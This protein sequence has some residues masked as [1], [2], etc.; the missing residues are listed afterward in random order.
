MAS[1]R[2]SSWRFLTKAGEPLERPAEWTE[3]LIEVFAEDWTAARVTRN[4]SE[5]AVYAGRVAHGAPR[6]LVDWPRSGAG[7]YHVEVTVAGQSEH[8]LVTLPPAKL[9][10]AAFEQLLED[11]QLRLP[12]SIAVSLARSGAL[13]GIELLPKAQST[14]AQELERARRAIHGRPG[15]PGLAAV[16]TALADD[17][18]RTFVSTDVWVRRERARRL[19]PARLPLLLARGGNLDADGMPERVPELRVE[20]TVDVYENRLVRT[21]H[22]QVANRVRRLRHVDGEFAVLAGQLG[23]ARRRASFLDDVRPPA[24]APDRVTMVLLKQPHY[25]AALEGFV[26]YTRTAAVQL[27]EPALEAPLENVPALYEHWGVLQ[28]LDVLLQQAPAAGFEITSTTLSRRQDAG[29]TI[30]LLPGGTP[31]AQ[32]RHQDGRCARLYLQRTYTRS[33]NPL[34]SVSFDK[35]PDAAL[36]IDGGPGGR[37]EVHIFDPK[38]KLVSE[39]ETP[40]SADID[41]MHAYRDA[42]RDS[43]GNPV[44]RSAAI[45]YPGQ[46][47]RY[48]DGLE[49]LRA[50]PLEPAEL[51]RALA[52]RL[53]AALV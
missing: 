42:I 45:L 26:E 37:A 4:G 52:K 18:H 5:L 6:V 7:R 39:R 30:Q 46:S 1:P 12:A 28:L 35:R 14:R 10:E 21:F 44:V 16:L 20:H 25:R 2:S 41:A 22:D 34:R 24:H 13:A 36:E 31:V 50:D 29:V 43:L 23:R 9:S 33:G 17:P 32:L 47:E 40:V 49:A 19:H 3:A 15:R 27:E 8:E 38:Y 51:R 48:D 53:R 11:L